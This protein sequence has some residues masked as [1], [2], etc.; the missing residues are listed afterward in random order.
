MLFSK[1]NIF[2][3]F[4]LVR[5]Q[6]EMSP[7]F[8]QNSAQPVENKFNIFQDSYTVAAKAA[9]CHHLTAFVR[10]YVCKNINR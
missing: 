3:I 10:I 5:I 8:I 1:P 2:R 9:N 4:R 7:T 6:Q